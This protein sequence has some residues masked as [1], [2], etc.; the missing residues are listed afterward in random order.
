M[1]EPKCTVVMDEECRE[2][3]DFVAVLAKEDGGSTLF[4][5]TDAMTLG[6]ACKMLTHEFMKEMAKL[7]EEDQEDIFRILNMT[8]GAKEEATA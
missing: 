2:S 4:Y 8:E 7:P 5:N 1:N 6:I 3:T